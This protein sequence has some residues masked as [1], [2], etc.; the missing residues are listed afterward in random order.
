MLIKQCFDWTNSKIII[1]VENG[2]KNYIP[3]GYSLFQKN[4][5]EVR[6]CS[7]PCSTSHTFAKSSK[8][9]NDRFSWNLKKIK[10]K[11]F[12]FLFIFILVNVLF[13]KVSNFY[14]EVRY[15]LV[16]FQP[17]CT[18]GLFTFDHLA[19]NILKKSNF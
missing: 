16:F 6:Y 19:K 10:E 8:K 9:A 17:S 18:F 2:G 1:M 11:G 15:F 13:F 12:V 5:G 7:E 4:R 3:R 14:H